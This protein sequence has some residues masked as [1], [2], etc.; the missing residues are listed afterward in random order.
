MH[1]KE[2]ILWASAPQ[3]L[4]KSHLPL[5]M[6]Q[7]PRPLVFAAL[8][9]LRGSRHARLYHETDPGGGTQTGD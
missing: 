6:G 4:T 9:T 1:P 8:R 2:T 7:N 5:G 3:K